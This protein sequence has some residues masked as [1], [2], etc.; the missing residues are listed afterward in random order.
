MSIFLPILLII[1]IIIA[2][3]LIVEMRRKP[4]DGIARNEA[5]G[6]F[7]Q[8]SQGVTHYQWLGPVRGPV[9]VCIHG[10][11]TPSFVWHAIAQGLILMGFR[12]LIYDLYGRGYSDRPAGKQDRDFFIRQLD[13]LLNNQNVEADITL[14]GYSMGGAIATTFAALHPDK[15][16]Q[17]VLLA[18]VGMIRNTTRLSDFI[19]N[20]PVI[21]DWLMQATF[22]RNQRKI[23]A[24]ESRSSDTAKGVAELMLGELQYKGF[25][26]AIL[27]SMR[28]MLSE[29]LRDEHNAIHDAGI[30]LLAVWARDDKLIPLTAMG[31]LTEWSRSAKQEVI[32]DAGHAMPYTHPEQVLDAI[33]E[34]MRDGIN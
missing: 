13:D 19:I 12:V 7:A 24:T 21:G 10:L 27:A 16:R 6:N 2:I 14:L 33:R 20:T 3:P 34:T 26:A 9:A 32:D 11:T 22:A 1:I 5:E 30:P 18:P 28:G 31:K 23:A 29:T 15:V 17:L 8:L 25:I 4:M